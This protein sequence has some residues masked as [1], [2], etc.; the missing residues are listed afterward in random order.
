MPN[1]KYI[2]GRNLEYRIKKYLESK[3]FTCTRSSGSKGY[4]DITA[5]SG[6]DVLLIQAKKGKLSP[7]ERRKIDLALFKFRGYKNVRAFVLTSDFKKEL[8]GEE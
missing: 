4:W 3:G 8:F 5:V 6:T 1:K 7:G 2:S